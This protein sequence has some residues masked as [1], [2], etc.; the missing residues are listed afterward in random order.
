MSFCTRLAAVSYS[1]LIA[2][3]ALAL[4][5][6]TP[7]VNTGPAVTWNPSG[8]PLKLHQH[9]DP[10]ALTG[11]NGKYIGYSTWDNNNYRNGGEW[12]HGYMETPA[13]YRF[14]ANFPANGQTDFND[15]VGKWEGLVNGN[16]VNS[17][18]VP[19]NISMNF[20]KAGATGAAEI[21]IAWTDLTSGAT[22]FWSPGATDFSFDS[23]PT[24]RI[25]AGA[26]GLVRFVGIGTGESFIRLSSEWHFGGTGTPGD[27]TRNYEY[28]NDG[29]TTWALRETTFKAYDFYTIALHE[30]GHA[31]G[32]DHFGTGIMREDIS[33]F[34]MRTPDAG[35]IDGMKDIYAI[36]VP[37]P[38]AMAGLAA[39]GLVW[40]RR[41]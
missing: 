10:D 18:G 35:S 27:V 2:T 37:E 34:V 31:W 41:R 8:D 15:A 21:D 1:L 25:N 30:L 17:N 32:L 24:V 23:N 39:L 33:G 3:P 13:L 16:E 6:L 7:H 19:I 28:S 20:N 5:S 4:P 22:A 11:G 12:G 29:G 26:G 14:G 38:M 40:R 36:A 9:R